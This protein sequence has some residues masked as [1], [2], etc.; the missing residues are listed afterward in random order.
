MP[1][2]KKTLKTLSSFMITLKELKDEI[3]LSYKFKV[4]DRP[5]E[6]VEHIIVLF[7]V[8]YFLSKKKT[9]LRRL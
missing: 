3:S 5:E 8:V 4:K 9:F 7:K 6:E 1:V 2:L